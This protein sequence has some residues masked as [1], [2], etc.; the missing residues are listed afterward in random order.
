MGPRA[1]KVN[2]VFQFACPKTDVREA[3][4]EKASRTV[5][6]W[7]VPAS[8]DFILREIKRLAARNGGVPPGRG[9]FERETGIRQSEWYPQIWLRWG[10][11]Q[12]EAGFTPTQL[13]GKIQDEV[14]IEHYISLMRELKLKR[15]LVIGEIRRKARTDKS[16][17][18]HT[19]F[20]RFGGKDKLIQAVAAYCQNKP[21]YEDISA[22]CASAEASTRRPTIGETTQTKVVVG[23]VYLMKSGRHYKIGRTS[24]VARRGGELTVKIPV[25]P[26]TIHSIETDDPVGV[27]AYW[28]KRFANK[29]GEGEWFELTTDDV[30]AFKRWKRIV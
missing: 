23:F 24:S 18:A 1:S 10:D 11:A 26:K 8:K 19:V 7:S 16:F 22:I 15:P 12:A 3:G 13:Q 21:E 14:V 6:D 4:I 2:C 27:E 9:A 30:T 5:S 20:N 28:H 29:R 17:P 25:P